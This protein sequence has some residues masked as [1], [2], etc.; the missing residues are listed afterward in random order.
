MPCGDDDC[1]R[2][3]H[4]TA[5][6]RQAC[7]DLAAGNLRLDEPTRASPRIHLESFLVAEEFA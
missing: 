3:A 2:G 1:Q 7:P 4:T 6:G 5:S